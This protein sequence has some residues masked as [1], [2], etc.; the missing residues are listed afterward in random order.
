VSVHGLAALRSDGNWLRMALSVTALL[1]LLGSA[2]AAD[3]ASMARQGEAVYTAQGCHGCHTIG[4]AGTPIAT[5]LTRIGTKYSEGYLRSWLADPSRQKPT[6][7]MPRIALTDAE[8]QA[9]AA[10][11]GSLR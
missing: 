10:Y 8:I 6:A 2:Q 11:L 7:H 5:D 9:L 1:I 4:K 3:R